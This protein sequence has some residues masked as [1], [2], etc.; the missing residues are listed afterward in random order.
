MQRFRVLLLLLC[1]FLGVAFAQVHQFDLDGDFL[2]RGELRVGG[3]EAGSET[4]EGDF[5]AFILGRSLTADLAYHF[6][7]TAAKLRN[8][9]Q[10]LGH[11]LE[12]SFSYDFGH[13][14]SLG[15]GYSFMRGTE[16]MVVLKRTSDKRELHWGW[17]ML[18]FAPRLF[19]SRR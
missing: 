6:L 2:S 10:P 8:A 14:M 1:L 4:A 7:A 18:R 9:E 3:N 15:V 19:Q 12:A 13:G 16:T 17:L 5:A 11:E